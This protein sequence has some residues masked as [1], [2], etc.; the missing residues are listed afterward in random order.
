MLHDL[1]FDNGATPR[2]FDAVMREGV[3]E[4]PAFGAPGTAA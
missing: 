3:I 1:D 2:F 4:V